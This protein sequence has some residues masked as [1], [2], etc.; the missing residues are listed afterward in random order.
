MKTLK[1]K[2]LYVSL[3]F[4]HREIIKDEKDSAF[5]SKGNKYTTYVSTFYPVLDII[6]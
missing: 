3:F 5:G 4:C 2:V 6:L 1:K